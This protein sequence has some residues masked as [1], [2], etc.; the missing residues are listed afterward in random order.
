MLPFDKPGDFQELPEQPFLWRCALKIPFVSTSP[1]RENEL[2]KDT[3]SDN[4]SFGGV[5][6]GCF[7]IYSHF[8]RV[9]MD[10]HEEDY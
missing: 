4:G 8:S 3:V 2:K 1:P 7:C 9:M 5:V 10:I 6:P